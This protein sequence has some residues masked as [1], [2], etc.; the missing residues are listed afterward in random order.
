MIAF[1][2]VTSLF[3][4]VHSW[5]WTSHFFYCIFGWDNSYNSMI[6]DEIK[7]Y[8]LNIKTRSKN[9]LTTAK[10]KS[11]WNS[12][13]RNL[14]YVI[15]INTYSGKSSKKECENFPHY[16]ETMIHYLEYSIPTLSQFTK[17]LWNTLNN[18]RCNRRYFIIV[19][20]LWHWDFT[21]H[22]LPGP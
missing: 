5:H 3:S 19:T 16:G 15:I 13:C 22:D 17:K 12:I 14:T 18:K 6:F 11:K 9:V 1:K 21:H 4:I 2:Y 10:L 20:S 7:H 8:F